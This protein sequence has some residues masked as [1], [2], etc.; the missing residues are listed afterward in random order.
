MEEIDMFS[1]ASKCAEDYL[2]THWD[3]S[4]PVDPTSLATPM[5]MSVSETDAL[6]PG[7]RGRLTR[8]SED[9]SQILASIRTGMPSKTARLIV[10]HQLGHVALGHLRH[11]T[12][13]E[14]TASTLQS[15]AVGLEDE[16][17]QFALSLLMPKRALRYAVERKGMTSLARLG[18]A[19]DVSEMALYIRLKNIGILS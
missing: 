6:P 15:D 17:N 18:E 16:A 9:T 5:R 3:G 19:F 8:A 12:T 11:E 7:I 2:L 13:F 1:T 14:E 10:A 4:T